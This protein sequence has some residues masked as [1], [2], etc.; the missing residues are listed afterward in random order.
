MNETL[1]RRPTVALLALVAAVSVLACP[2]TAQAAVSHAATVPIELQGVHV[3]VA[4][5][6]NG[7][8]ATF[9]LD[10]GASAN[11]I[12]PA[13]AKRLGLSPGSQQTP[14]IGA[15]GRAGSVASVKIA[16]LAVGA[17]QARNQVA[18]V[19]RLPEAMPCDGLLGTPFLRDRIVKIDYES[20]K[21]MLIPK[22]EFQPPAGAT[23]L[24]LRFDGNTPFVEAHAD[25]HSGWFRMDTGADNGATL[26][27][28]FVE[29]NH[30]RGRYS[31]AIRIVTGRGVGGLLMGDLV[32]LPL[33]QIGPYKFVRAVAELSRQ[34][35][36]TFGDKRNAGNIG[37]EVW[38]RFTLTLDYADRR[39]YIEP[40]S[41]FDRPFAV[42]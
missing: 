2:L 24:P 4:V 21:L 37:G 35:E 3:F 22:S 31:P 14:L 9:V 1:L 42:P 38:Q 12:T 28:A 23:V 7:K 15:A 39:A 32:R 16:L 18:Y 25:G 10:T 19:I 20:S 36:G 8:P 29:S 13:A 27:S 6:V 30:L 40:N 41:R 33:L 11:V 34:T 5:S 17:T 26:F